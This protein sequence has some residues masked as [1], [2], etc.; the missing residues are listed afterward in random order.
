M[1]S[2]KIGKFVQT[3]E[4]GYFNMQTKYIMVLPKNG[5]DELSVFM[6]AYVSYLGFSRTKDLKTIND[7]YGVDVYLDVDSIHPYQESS[8]SSVKLDAKG[9]DKDMKQWINQHTKFYKMN[10]PSIGE[11]DLAQKVNLVSSKLEMAIKYL[12]DQE[13]SR[14]VLQVR[15]SSGIRHRVQIKPNTGSKRTTFNNLLV[16]VGKGEQ[17]PK[18]VLNTPKPRLPRNGSVSIQFKTN[19][20][21]FKYYD[22]FGLFE[23]YDKA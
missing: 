11:S 12:H 17:L 3:N 19:P 20:D 22:K 8:F 13:D 2:A 1:Y 15:R 7:R 23:I 16:V 4:F 6:D 5:L 21:S 9:F 14:K 10:D 18:L